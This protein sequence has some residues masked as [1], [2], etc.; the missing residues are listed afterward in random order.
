MDEVTGTFT[1]RCPRTNIEQ[2]LPLDALEIDGFCS[3]SEYTSAHFISFRCAVCD[4]WHKVHLT[5]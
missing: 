1:Y 2:Q 5:R 4:E 3:D